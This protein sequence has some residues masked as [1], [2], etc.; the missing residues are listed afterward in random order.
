MV[1][2]RCGAGAGVDQVRDAACMRWMGGKISRVRSAVHTRVVVHHL[3]NDRCRFRV[4][5]R[6]S[7]MTMTLWKR[8][9]MPAKKQSSRCDPFFVRAR[10]VYE[11]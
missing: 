6:T 3:P 5:T 2:C 4:I 11:R 1:Q 10:Q 8:M 7:R 9:M